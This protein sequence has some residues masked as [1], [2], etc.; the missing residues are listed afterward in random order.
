MLDF[1]LAYLVYNKLDAD[2]KNLFENKS[3]NSGI[4][5]YKDL[6]SFIKTQAQIHTNLVS[7]PSTSGY[8]KPYLKQVQ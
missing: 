5:K 8:T 2:S 7:K 3:D 6:L 1:V 4:F